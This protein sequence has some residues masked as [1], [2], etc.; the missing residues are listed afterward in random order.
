MDRTDAGRPSDRH[1]DDGFRKTAIY[2]R[3][4]AGTS[5]HAV[6]LSGRGSRWRA[7]QVREWLRRAGQAA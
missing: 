4:K 7:G 5:A 3:M 6:R 1:G 2:A